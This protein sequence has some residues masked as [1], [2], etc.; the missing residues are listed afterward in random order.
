MNIQHLSPLSFLWCF[1]DD[2]TQSDTED[3]EDW[4]R[5]EQSTCFVEHTASFAGTA[6]TTRTTPEVRA[7][8]VSSKEVVLNVN[9]VTKEDANSNL[10]VANDYE[11]SKEDV[12]SNLAVVATDEDEIDNAKFQSSTVAVP[13]TTTAPKICAD[14]LLKEEVILNIPT[15]GK[16]I[17]DEE[18]ISNL[19]GVA[20]NDGKVAVSTTTTTTTVVISTEIASTEKVISDNPIGDKIESTTTTATTGIHTD[21]TNN[22]SNSNIHNSKEEGKEPKDVSLNLNDGVAAYDDD[23][24]NAKAQP[25]CKN[26]IRD[27]DGIQQEYSTA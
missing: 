3:F 11:Y 8:I 6:T 22:Y 14:M 10:N 24:D 9:V 15:I 23:I 26:S 27:L 1:I 21:L 19:N 12:S 4:K 2:P 20:D 7:D 5:K 18:V 13:T 16:I 17:S 25:E